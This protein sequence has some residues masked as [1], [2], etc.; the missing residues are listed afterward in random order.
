MKRTI[1]GSIAVASLALWATSVASADEASDFY[2]GRTITLIGAG[3][4]AGSYGV[5]G[6]VVV[7]FLGRH[8]PGKPN[9]IFQSMPGA[10]GAKAANYLY[11]AAAKDGT[12]IGNPLKYIAV[13]QAI[14][15]P[16]VKY[17]VRK[18]NWLISAAAINSVVAIWHTAPA[19]TLDALR[20]TEIVMGS[21]GKS[22]ETYITP[23]MM[24]RYLG[25]KFK[26]VT[27]YK[28]TGDIHLAM[29][30]GE[31]HGRAAAWESIKGTKK[32][33]LEKKQVVMIAQSGLY[34]D[35][36]LPDVPRL[37]DLAPNDEVRTIFEFVST[38]S[39]LGRVF[40]APPDVPV[41]RV[42]ALRGGFTAMLNDPAFK[43]EAR[44]LGMDIEPRTA[45][46]VEAIIAKTM[47]APA[48][49]IESTKEAMK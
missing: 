36:D 48:A 3:G 32:E 37:I 20:Q 13:E 41:A 22:S 1:C 25:T 38:A 7:E 4:E 35:P 6:R 33:W 46:E 45:K 27:G 23:A 30:R 26:I 47:S 19:R 44:R 5:W 43:V 18:L 14:G 34:K 15:R 24:N 9:I 8:V 29:E 39:T 40:F 49:V 16:S 42:E 11:N 10:G 31:L 12:I 28:G 21:S 2:S 17:D